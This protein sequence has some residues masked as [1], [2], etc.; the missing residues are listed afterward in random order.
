MKTKKHSFWLNYYVAVLLALILIVPSFIFNFNISPTQAAIGLD[1]DGDPENPYKITCTADLKTFADWVN[2]GNTGENK[3]FELTCSIDGSGVP[4]IG[5]LVYGTERRFKGTFDGNGFSISNVNRTNNST[6]QQGDLGLFGYVQGTIKNLIVL[7][8]TITLSVDG[9]SVGAIAGSTYEGSIIERCFNAG[10]TVQV[11]SSNMNA[12]QTGGIIGAAG[13]STTIKYSG[14]SAVIKNNSKN[15]RAGGIM[16]IQNEGTTT[17]TECYNTGSITAGTSSSNESFAGGI[18]GQNG[19]VNNCYNTGAITAKARTNS[20]IDSNEHELKGWGFSNE[21][22]EGI[23]YMGTGLIDYRYAEAIVYDD[24]DGIPGYNIPAYAAGIAGMSSNI[25]YCY[26]IGKISGGYSN[27][28]YT[29]H[30]LIGGIEGSFLN[31][32]YAD[33]VVT[34]INEIIRFANPITNGSYNTYSRNYS[35]TN[36]DTN[37]NNIYSCEYSINYYPADFDTKEV[38]FIIDD[39]STLGAY[40]DFLSAAIKRN[41]VSFD[42]HTH[43]YHTSHPNERYSR[44]FSNTNSADYT[45]SVPTYF[46]CRPMSSEKLSEYGMQ[47][48]RVSITNS[49]TV[50]GRTITI[51]FLYDRYDYY[52][53]PG[54]PDKDDDLGFA[55]VI[56]YGNDPQ[57]P[58]TPHLRT[59]N[60]DGNKLRINL[61]NNFSRKPSYSTTSTLTSIPSGFNSA[62]W[63]INSLINNNHPYLKNIYWTNSALGFEN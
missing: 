38:D 32:Y 42:C 53:D 3:Y 44:N 7:N 10:C 33:Y 41:F 35:I 19:T 9:K 26:N 62:I 51:N 23:G 25:S 21:L 50:Q 56:P 45:Q 30:Y 43:N 1:G 61:S 46:G 2:S 40:E 52:S 63:G 20:I 11:T 34:N 13:G 28:K 12:A 24:I 22:F 5:S 14:N 37:N 15:A 57:K 58:P 4:V 48:C 6:N 49:E 39:S 29:I 54:A 59:Q 18:I 55:E 47:N 17:I 60:D 16:G 27:I 8:G 31:D 36:T